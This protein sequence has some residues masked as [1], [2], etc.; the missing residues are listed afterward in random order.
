[1]SVTQRHK[2]VTAGLFDLLSQGLTWVSHSQD[3]H[4]LGGRIVAITEAVFSVQ[5]HQ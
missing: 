5:I 4:V 3:L 1:M 2:D